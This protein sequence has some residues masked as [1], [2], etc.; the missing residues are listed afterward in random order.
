MPTAIKISDLEPSDELYEHQ[1]ITCD[2][3]QSSIRIDKFLIDKLDK[4]RTEQ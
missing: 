3:N 2:K 4:L 1:R